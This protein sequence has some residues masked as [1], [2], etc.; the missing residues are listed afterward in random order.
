MRGMTRQRLSSESTTMKSERVSVL[1]LSTGAA[2]NEAIQLLAREFDLTE[3]LNPALAAESLAHSG[4]SIIVVHCDQTGPA[5]FQ[6][7]RQIKSS[8]S[9]RNIPLVLAVADT[10]DDEQA[11]QALESGAS[12]IIDIAGLPKLACARI[13]SLASMQQAREPAGPAN[14]GSKQP[15]VEGV[16][17]PESLT[18]SHRFLRSLLDHAPAPIYVVGK[19]GRYRLVNRGWGERVSKSSEEAIGKT[20]SD[21]WPAEPARSMT[22]IDQYIIR[23]GEPV[24][25]EES[26]DTPTGQRLYQSVKFPVFDSMGQVDA[27][28]GISI[29]ITGIKRTEVALRDSERRYQT[30]TEVSPVGIFYA[31]PR[32]RC[33][34]VNDRWCEIAGLSPG[35]AS[36][37]GWVRALHPDDRERVLDEWRRAWEE[38]RS[39][40]SEYR[41]ERSNGEV[42]WGFA[43]GVAEKARDGSV[44]GYVGTITDITEL[45]RAQE[46]LSRLASIVESSDDAILSCTTD[47]RITSWNAGAEKTYGYRA[48]EAIGRS[49]SF[50]I[51]PDHPD[52]TML[53]LA[54]ITRPESVHNYEVL[55]VKRDGKSII[56]SLTVSPIRDPAG[57]VIGASLIARDVTGSHQLQEELR[58]AQKMDAIGRLAG[59]VAHDFHNL[60]SAINGYS[61]L[62][63]MHL[64]ENDPVYQNIAEIRKSGER[65]ASLTRQLLAFGRKQL[66]QPQILDLN[67]IIT[68][69]NKM[70]RRLI[71][72]DIELVTHA[73]QGLGRVKADPGQIEQIIV[74]LAVNARDAMPEGGRLTIETGNVPETEGALVR[75]PDGVARPCGL[76]KVTR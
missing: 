49:I 19:D 40:R 72:E 54:N 56:V 2:P 17:E 10:F 37:T 41:F 22:E 42:A 59:G 34:Y 64:A 74:N 23:T 1:S 69:M 18:E 33:I 14:A 26:I 75:A 47:G 66:L 35:E 53:I 5:A 44:A 73:V 20:R 39:F 24:M 27:V 11:Q 52:D 62:T 30:L 43:Q 61:D 28:G 51:P 65:A 71:G 12:D 57:M 15:G 55:H 38:S 31:D 48:T 45:R 32:A 76:I 13:R 36:G 67:V 7:C 25:T 4:A 60:L 68:D 6:L 58:Q 70:L 21:L 29:D 16:P 8:L 9:G 50:L 63:L 46:G 3:V